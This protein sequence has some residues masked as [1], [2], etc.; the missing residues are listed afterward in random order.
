MGCL[1]AD[2]TKTTLTYSC[3]TERGHRGN[4]QVHCQFV[5]GVSCDTSSDPYTFNK[6]CFEGTVYYFPTKVS[7]KTKLSKF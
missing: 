5:L 4:S 2:R 7:Q 1:T 6:K 3:R